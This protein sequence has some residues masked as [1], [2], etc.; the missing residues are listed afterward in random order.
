LLDQ[1]H[2]LFASLFSGA[3]IG[4]L[5][6][7]SA[8]LQAVAMCELER[9]RSALSRINFPESMH[10]TG[11]VCEMGSAFAQVVRDAEAV[12]SSNLFLL[13][14]TAP[15][16]GMSKSGQGTLLKNIREGKRPVLDPRNALIL[17]A[18]DIIVELQPLWVVFENVIEMRSTSIMDRKGK[19]R[20]ILD[21]IAET[22]GNNYI[23]S[24]YDVEFADY[25]VPQRRQRLITVFTRDQTAKWNYGEGWSFIPPPTHDRDGRDGKFRWV[26]VAEALKDFPPL[27]A[28]N[29]SLSK[30]KNI[31]FHHVPLLDAKKYEWVRH[32]KAGQSAFDNQCINPECMFQGNPTHGNVSNG[33]INQSKRDTP[34]YCV[35]CGSLLPRPY[36]HS[37]SGEKRIM[38]GFTSAYKRMSADSPSPALTR[39]FSYACSDNKVHPHENR[40]L[41]LA[42]A[43]KLQ[44]ITDYKY[45]WGPFVLNGKRIE[46]APDGLIRLVIGES[47]PPMFTWLLASHLVSMSD[48]RTFATGIRVERTATQ[49]SLL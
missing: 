20:P 23:G 34:L 29:S 35:K 41:S 36:A 38:S 12:V 17:P 24:A 11:D 39:N 16:Q 31:P 4:D 27:D 10:L 44:T 8:G 13:S 42:E 28:S 22:L 14:C 26:T 9:D 6:Y 45:K 7:R 47:V 25:G 46:R 3:G 15:C 2:R 43:M 19:F 30:S 49:L 40:V 48:S 21:I 37:A 5:G 18:L 32:T 1:Q 33:G